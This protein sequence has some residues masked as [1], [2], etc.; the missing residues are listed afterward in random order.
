MCSIFHQLAR[1]VMRLSISTFSLGQD[2]SKIGPLNMQLRFLQESVASYSF[3]LYMKTLVALKA[4][5]Q[6]SKS[7]PVCF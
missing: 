6:Q 3:Y 7:Q 4:C 5:L 2:I 1:A